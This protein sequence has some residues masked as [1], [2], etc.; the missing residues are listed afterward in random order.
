[1]DSQSPIRRHQ[2]PTPAP[3]AARLQAQ[4]ILAEADQV[5][6]AICDELALRREHHHATRRTL[7]RAQKQLDRADWVLRIARE[8]REA[9]H[10][11][12]RQMHQLKR[13][14]RRT[15]EQA[16]ALCRQRSNP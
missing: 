12:L 11:A 16:E 9:A 1:M 5:D 15:I 3:L 14:H 7:E 2:P 13:R 8:Q 10:T 4:A 6:A